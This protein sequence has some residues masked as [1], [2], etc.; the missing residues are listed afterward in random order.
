MGQ[1]HQSQA[2]VL[3]VNPEASN[4]TVGGCVFGFGWFEGIEA[5][6]DS[7]TYGYSS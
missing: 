7:V 6:Q 4:K 1:T 2:D 3:C 5:F